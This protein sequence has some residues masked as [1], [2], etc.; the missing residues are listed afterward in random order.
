MPCV[1]VCVCVCVNPKQSSLWL[2]CPIALE[3]ALKEVLRMQSHAIKEK[4][5]KRNVGQIICFPIDY[6]SKC[7]PAE[8]VFM[9][10]LEN[11]CR[12]LYVKHGFRNFETSIFGEGESYKFGIKN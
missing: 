4:E 8:K 6:L 10:T 7:G 5:R 9:L 2:K 12:E 1:C 11:Y 3:S